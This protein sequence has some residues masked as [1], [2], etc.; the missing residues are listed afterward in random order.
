MKKEVTVCMTAFHCLDMYTKRTGVV[1]TH[2]EPSV[3]SPCYISGREVVHFGMGT[4][5]EIFDLPIIQ[6][7][8]SDTGFTNPIN[9]TIHGDEHISTSARQYIR[10]TR[11]AWIDHT[12]VH[13]RDEHRNI[14]VP[15]WCSY[16]RYLHVDKRPCPCPDHTCA[17]QLTS[18]SFGRQII[19]IMFYGL[20]AFAGSVI[21]YIPETHL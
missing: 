8:C 4:R 3:A 19:G 11:V 21:S 18:P 15:P 10:L 6:L 14:I 20:T 17:P 16:T 12:F 9:H 1:K 5:S 7:L 2:N 13:H